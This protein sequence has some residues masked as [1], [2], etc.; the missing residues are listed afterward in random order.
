MVSPTQTKS[1]FKPLHGGF[2][3]RRTI[4]SWAVHVEFV[5]D[6][7][8]LGQTLRVS[9][10]SCQYNS[11][12]APHS[13]FIHLSSKIYGL[14]NLQCHSIQDTFPLYCHLHMVETTLVSR[15]WWLN[16]RKHTDCICRVKMPVL[17]SCKLNHSSIITTHIFQTS[18]AIIYKAVQTQWPCT[19]RCT[20]VAPRLLE[21]WVQI[22]LGARMFC[23]RVSCV[24]WR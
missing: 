21:S 4:L 7:M 6:K 17:N 3:Q 2:L 22:L 13:Y 16:D 8:I 24:L 14:I 5:V 15:I 18:G 12:N 23:Y 19:L 9:D 10:F 11:I 20:S 1:W